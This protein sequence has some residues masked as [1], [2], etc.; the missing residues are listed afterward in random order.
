MNVLILGVGNPS[1]GDD[2]LGPLLIERL[3]GRVPTGIEL[4]TDFQ[5][6]VEHLLDLHGRDLV[7]FADASVAAAAPFAFVPAG[8]AAS[9]AALATTT[10]AMEPAALLAAYV[11]HY[12]TAPPPAWVLAMR[13]ESFELGAPP[14]DDAL[15]HL[16]AA[17]GFL[18]AWLARA[19]ARPD[20]WSSPSA[21]FE[22]ETETETSHPPT[23]GVASMHT[24]LARHGARR[25]DS[26]LRHDRLHQSRSFARRHDR[27]RLQPA[28]QG[29]A[30]RR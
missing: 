8:P 26:E 19:A 3:E 25:R 27:A 29:H 13:A 7:V 23:A 14:G 12:G 16:Q 18:E 10:H 6:Q 2:A 4:L 11:R 20:G 21:W 28:S 17:A 22:T 15:R 1:R 24:P 5:L 30:G 9:G